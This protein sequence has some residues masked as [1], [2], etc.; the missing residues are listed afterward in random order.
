[1][2]S[3]KNHLSLIVALFTILLTLQIF[4][5]VDRTID[6]YEKNLNEN[7]SIIV[8]SD[9][10]ISVDTFR[11]IDPM[12]SNSEEISPKQVIQKLQKE[13]KSKSINLHKIKLP[14]FYRIHLDHFP[15][16]N[17]VDTVTLN[18]QK[19]RTVKRVESFSRSHTTIYRLLLLFKWVVMIFAV[20]IF[21]VTTLLIL[22]EMRLWQL[23]HHERMNIMALFGA[24]V[25][26]R[27]AV[28]F[29][30]AIVDA[31]IATVLVFGA[32]MAAEHYGIS[33]EALQMIGIQIP[34]F[35]PAHDMPILFGVAISLSIVLA[36]LIV[37]GHKEEV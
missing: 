8:I 3:F 22:R 14:K 33:K 20:A 15:T 18:L 29:R 9:T 32:F 27:S 25:W 2:R 36:S 23:Q 5:N 19:G 24:P 13:I 21:T 12:I 26:L 17:E 7:Y 1:M 31:L 34:L 30:L 4:I 11:K 28:L 37:M 35:N 16:P 6:I 10:N